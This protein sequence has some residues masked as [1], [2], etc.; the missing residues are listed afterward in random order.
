VSRGHR[1]VPMVLWDLSLFEDVSCGSQD[2]DQGKRVLRH[3][4][5]TVK[6]ISFL[7]G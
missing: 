7:A 2:L 4:R 5:R 6:S 1:F 3:L